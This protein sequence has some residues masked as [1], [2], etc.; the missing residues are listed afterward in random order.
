MLTNNTNGITSYI[1]INNVKRET[2]KRFKYLGSIISDDGSTPE[3]LSRIA[4]T[5]AALTRLKNIWRDTN[6]TIRSKIKVLR[7][8]VMSIF[9]YACETWTLTANLQKKIQA[10]ELR[11]YRRLL[12]ISYKDHITNEEILKTIT[13]HV[14]NYENLLTT[15]KKIKLRWYGHV[16]RT[17]GLSKTTLQGTVPGGRKRGRQRKRWTDNIAE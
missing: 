9:L 4:Q 17:N 15:V 6:I 2:T 12:G 8:L 14:N 1:K 11:C 16:T 5:T 10:M 3:M 7:S 13:K